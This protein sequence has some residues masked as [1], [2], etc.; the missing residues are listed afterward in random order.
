MNPHD[1]FERTSLKSESNTAVWRGKETGNELF[2][3]SKQTIFF[4]WIQRS[5]N[6]VP[7]S[8]SA[9]GGNG[10]DSPSVDL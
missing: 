1:Y 2:V 7:V 10:G 5:L 9:V 3:N 6:C 8:C 4:R